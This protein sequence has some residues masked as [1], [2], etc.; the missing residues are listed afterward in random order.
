[1]LPYVRPQVLNLAIMGPDWS[2]WSPAPPQPP[3][4]LP[5]PPSDNHNHTA[6][7]THGHSSEGAGWAEP[8]TSAGSSSELGHEQGRE[9]NRGEVAHSSQ[10]H[11][12][13]A[14]RDT[15]PLPTHPNQQVKGPERGVMGALKVL[16]VLGVRA[17]L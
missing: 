5:P 17:M 15:P 1:M 6:G 13:T 16:E 9:S 7:A 12:K 14:A 10:V 11:D 4:P 2:P 8:P 3:Q